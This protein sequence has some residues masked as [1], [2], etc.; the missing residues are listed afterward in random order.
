MTEFVTNNI[1]TLGRRLVPE[2][3]GTFIEYLESDIALGSIH[4]I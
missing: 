3:I 2:E 4:T 1:L